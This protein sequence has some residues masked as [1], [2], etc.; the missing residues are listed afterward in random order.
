MMPL[1]LYH[2]FPTGYD[3]VRSFIFSVITGA[4]GSGLMVTV[5][6]SETTVLGIAHSSSEV[7]IL[8]TVCLSVSVEVVKR[9]ELVPTFTP[10]TCH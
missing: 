6:P 5:I 1:A 4:A 10:S 2:W 3:E 9:V 8:V 7:I